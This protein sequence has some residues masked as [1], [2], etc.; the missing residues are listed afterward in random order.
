MVEPDSTEPLELPTH[1]FG[2][3][4]GKRPPTRPS[5]HDVSIRTIGKPYASSKLR[6]MEICPKQVGTE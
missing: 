4:D 1:A 3:Y 6:A 5:L 2:L